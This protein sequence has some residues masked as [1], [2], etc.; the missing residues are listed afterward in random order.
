MYG[1]DRVFAYMR[2]DQGA[3]AAQDRAVDALGKAGHPVI[4]I[5][6]GYLQP[7]QEMFRWEI[8]TAVAGRR[9]S[10]SMRFN[11]P[12][13][14]A[15]K[16]ATRKLTSEYEGPGSLPA[17][18]PCLGGRR[19]AFHR[20]QRIAALGSALGATDRWPGYLRAHLNRLKAGDYFAL[21]A[22][23]EMNESARERPA[24]PCA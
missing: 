13:V 7:G 23:I 10:A 3:D 24:E 9:S 11:Q 8:A 14:E 22:Y 16:I 17:E 4:R 20:R 12:D 6:L 1:N 21:L 19:Q 2:L 5:A 18:R 15:S